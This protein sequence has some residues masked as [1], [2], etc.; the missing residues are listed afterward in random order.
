MDA[1]IHKRIEIAT[2]DQVFAA[3]PAPQ[4][5]MAALRPAHEALDSLA[6]EWQALAS[7]G[8]E[9]NVFSQYWFMAPAIRHLAG[10]SE[11]MLLE[12]RH[13]A[14]LIGV[15]PLIIGRRYGRL[16]VAHV[17]NWLS[18]HSFLGTPLIRKGNET[19]FW[20]AA[21][22]A[23]DRQP[24]A[25]GLFYVTEL[26]EHGPAHQ[27]LIAAARAAG[28]PADTVFRSERALL[29][30]DLAPEAYY[31]A[32]VRKKKRKELK[33][34][35]NRLDEL[36]AVTTSRLADRAELGAWCDAFLALEQSGW[37]GRQGSALNCA[38]NTRAFFHE[39]AAGAFDAGKLDLLR[40]DLDGKP[41]AM[42]VNFLSAPG[43]FSFKIAFDEDYSRFS[44]GVLIQLENLALLERDDIAWMDSCAVEDH[45]M[46]NSLWGERRALVRVSVPLAGRRLLFRICRTLETIHH[47]IKRRVSRPAPVQT[48]EEHD[49]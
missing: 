33:R 10:T 38:E 13:G 3:H 5:L 23:L 48:Q 34:L 4:A 37:K 49:D 43:S 29:E 8:G 21:L 2:E 11:V 44:P 46:I 32:T 17:T 42:L 35:R 18:Y 26:V 20:S 19:A 6:L 36:G 16:P 40:L 9:A 24:W 7:L 47:A 27:G 30:S 39:A 45:P 15:M 31:E 22:R 14:S 12:V 25:R 1:A 28:R 41:I